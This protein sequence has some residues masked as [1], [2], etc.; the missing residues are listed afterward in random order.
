MVPYH[1]SAE[2]ISS[3]VGVPVMDCVVAG[4]KTAEMLV[5]MGMKNSRKAYPRH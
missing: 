3:E 1:F 4:I 5:K 2:E